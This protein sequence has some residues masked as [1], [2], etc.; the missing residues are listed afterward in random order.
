[1]TL[2]VQYKTK[3]AFKEAVKDDPTKVYI[4]APGLHSP[5]EEGFLSEVMKINDHITVT[6]HPKRSWFASV[7]NGKKGLVVG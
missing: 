3:K 6:N 7:K 5:A 2:I 4:E 1:M